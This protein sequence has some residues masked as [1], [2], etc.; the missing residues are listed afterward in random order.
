MKHSLP[1]ILELVISYVEAFGIGSLRYRD[2]HKRD[3]A[4]RSVRDVWVFAR[5]LHR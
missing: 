2:C 1:H 4:C 5:G 3:A